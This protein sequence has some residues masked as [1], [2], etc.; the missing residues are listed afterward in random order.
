MSHPTTTYSEI[1]NLAAEMAD[2]T[3]DNL[4]TS[5]ATMLRSFLAAD[6]LEMWVQ[7]AWPEISDNMEA[8][9]LDT[10]RCFDKRIGE[11][12]EMGDILAVIIGGNPMA[13]TAVQVLPKDQFTELDGRVNTMFSTPTD[14]LQTGSTPAVFVNWQLPVPDLTAVADDELDDYELPIRF[15]LPLVWKAAAKLL[16]PEDPPRAAQLDAM[17]DRLLLRMAQRVPRPW[18]RN[19]GRMI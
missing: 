2:R 15:K 17:A 6:L 8:V 10:D 18:W 16:A 14:S 13:T 1:K 12:N 3:R 5:E 19:A 4:P 11:T 7:E 9:E